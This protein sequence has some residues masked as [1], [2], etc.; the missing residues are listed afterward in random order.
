MKLEGRVAVVTG[1]AMGMGLE[2]SLLLAKAG[3]AG[4]AMC[5]SLWLHANVIESG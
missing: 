2:L 4:I 1:A 5:E 3:C